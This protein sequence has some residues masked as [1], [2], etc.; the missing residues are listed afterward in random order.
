VTRKLPLLA[1]VLSLLSAG[2]IAQNA[3]PYPIPVTCST[4]HDRPSP[5]SADGLKSSLPQSDAIRIV[6]DGKK[7]PGFLSMPEPE[8]LGI[9]HYGIAE[10]ATCKD[11]ARCYWRDLQTQLDKASTELKRLVG[12]KKSGEKL[13]MVLDIDET[14]LSNYCEQSREGFGFVGSVYNAYLMSTDASI[15]IP[16]TLALF[17]QAQAAGVDVYFITGR[18]NDQTETTARNLRIAGYDH[19]AGLTLRDDHERNMDTTLY[20]SNER[21][22]IA[23]DHRIILSVGDQWSDLNGPNAAEVS[24]KL[25]NPFYFIP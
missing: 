4:A 11:S 7:Q 2:S 19:W 13:A 16:G 10:Y 14:S 17:N 22:K 6:Q 12:T 5:P 9:L 25:P 8:N 3:V 20:K 23:L 1:V 21:A 15:P 24:V 18:N